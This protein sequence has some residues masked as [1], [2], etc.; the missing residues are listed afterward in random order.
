[1]IWSMLT[2]R[3]SHLRDKIWCGHRRRCHLCECHLEIPSGHIVFVDVF[4]R[5]ISIVLVRIVSLSDISI[6]RSEM[7][8]S[9]MSPRDL[10]M[11]SWI[12]GCHLEISMCHIVFVHVFYRVIYRICRDGVT[13]CTCHL[14]ISRCRCRHVIQNSR[15]C[16]SKLWE[17]IVSIVSVITWRCLWMSWFLGVNID[18]HPDISRWYRYD[19]G[20]P[21]VKLMHKFG[22]TLFKFNNI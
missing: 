13:I 20:D 14:V 5:V 8:V 15:R 2:C 3:H 17:A 11:S 16:H 9:S 21:S 12:S 18:S 22:V 1:M 7:S 10:E 4:Y 6:W 19:P